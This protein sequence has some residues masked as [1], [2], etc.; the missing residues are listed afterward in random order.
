MDSNEDLEGTLT[1]EGPL[2]EMAYAALCISKG[3]EV[4]PR[5]ETLGVYHDVFIKGSKGHIFCECDGESEITR[6]KV[7]LFRDEVLRLNSLLIS[8][9]QMP[10]SE[11]RFIVMLPRGYWG[12]EINDLMDGVRSEFEKSSIRLN[13]VEPKRLLYDLVSSSIIGFML[14]D[15]HI[16]LAGP[17]HWAIRYNASVSRFEFGDSTIPL[18]RFRKL[19]QSFIAR[20]YWNERHK[21]IYAEYVR[22]AEESLPEWFSW[23]F[24]EN[25]GATWRSPEQMAMAILRAYSKN[26][27]IIV[28][29]GSRGFVSMRKLKKNSYYTANLVYKSGIIGAEDAAR[30][31]L[32]LKA[33]V[34]NFQESG[35][36]MDDLDMYF[37]LFTDTV[38]FSHMYWT[39]SRFVT[40]HG[41]PFYTEIHR[42]DDVLV[43]TLNSGDLGLKLERNRIRL[44]LEEN[45]NSLSLVRGSLQW[46]S[47]EEGTYPATLKF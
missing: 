40:H 38:T 19:P 36:M 21:D 11:A 20:D 9:E 4:A 32:E 34:D 6:E 30:I 16:I 44:S 12:D 37:R 28:H 23:K 39:R 27:R 14:I 1:L 24:P 25:F 42:G 41:E 15:D 10:I 2:L 46:E 8:N 26:G 35:E 29:K 3:E 45:P 7:T 13:I 33:L 31:E 22:M 18:D 5:Q 43:E 47:S 17:G